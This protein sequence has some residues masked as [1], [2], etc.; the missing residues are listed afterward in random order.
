MDPHVYPGDVGKIELTETHISFLFFTG[1]YVYKVKKPVDFGFLDFTSLA[2]RK[3]Y[4]HEEVSLNSGLAPGVYIGVI[5]I[6]LVDGQYAVEG[7]GTP[8]EYAVKMRQLPRY[9]SL[10]N[11]IDSCQISKL[12]I[13]MISEKVASFHSD[14]ETSA[15]ITELGGIRVVRQNIEE[16]FTQIEKFIGSSIS[17]RVFQDLKAYSHAF[18]NAK[19][20]SFSRRASQGCIRDCH[21]DLRAAHFFLE[22]GPNG[23]KSKVNIIDRIEFNRRFRYSDVANDVAFLAMDLDYRQQPS[24]S[25]SFVDGYIR[26]SGDMG[27]R[28]FIDFFKIYRAFVRGKISS[29][30]MEGQNLSKEDRKSLLSE[31]QGYFRLAHS[32][33]P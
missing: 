5:P 28:E 4:C 2:K 31:A 14:A 26:A 1:E 22:D 25:R 29:F 9:R 17:K 19:E 15:K 6:T 21:G 23:P 12:E 10:D 18:L 20:D 30:Q 3:K 32:Y 13:A 27:I 33:L 24:L 16:N 11:L 8:V 7:P